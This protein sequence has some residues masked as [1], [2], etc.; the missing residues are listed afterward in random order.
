[1]NIQTMLDEIKAYQ[2]DLGYTFK[3]DSVEARVEHLRVLALAQMMEV[4][5]FVD[6]I[7]WKPWRPIEDQKFDVTEA[8]YELIDQF[9]FMANLWSALGMPTSSFEV[10]FETKLKENRDRIKRGYNKP[11][12][13]L[14]LE[15]GDT[16]ET[17]QGDVS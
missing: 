13:Q 16:G 8:A 14:E 1:M 3:Y 4:A 6:W 15:Y 5:E 12:K 11:I 10:L 17:F 2:N 7:P 9:F